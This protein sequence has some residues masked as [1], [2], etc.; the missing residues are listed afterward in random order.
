MS[1]IFD[2]LPRFLDP[3]DP[4]VIFEIGAHEGQETAALRLLFPSLRTRLWAFEPDP[5]SAHVLRHTEYARESA[6][7][8]ITV[9]EAAASDTDGSATLHLSSGEPPHSPGTPPPQA[10]GP[11]ANWTR[12]SSLKE[13]V[14]IKRLTPWVKFD[15]TATVKTVRLDTYC[16]QHRLRQIDLLWCM[17][18]GS[19]DLVLAGAQD[20]LSRTRLLYI[21][22]ADAELYRGQLNSK[23]IAERLPNP[24][25]WQAIGGTEATTLFKNLDAYSG[26]YM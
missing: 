21:D 26:V 11:K 24:A 25:R 2:V 14:A 9:V 20:I 19:Q 10:H 13:P 16:Q 1:T 5:R 3:R 7:A 23:Q 17:P 4:L 12:A 22:S 6:K 15:Q 18:A 8:G